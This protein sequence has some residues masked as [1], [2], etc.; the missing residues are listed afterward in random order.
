MC[1]SVC[2]CMWV[3][4]VLYVVVFAPSVANIL[5]QTLLSYRPA[6]QASAAKQIKL[7]LVSFVHLVVRVHV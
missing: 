1:V 3:C 5:L 4:D 6:V 2:E 7:G